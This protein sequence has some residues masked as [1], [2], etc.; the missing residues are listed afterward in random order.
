MTLWEE[1]RMNVK[2]LQWLLK[3]QATLLQIV[4]VAKGFRKG[5]PYAEQWVIVD[6]IARLVIPLLESESVNPKTLAYYDW[7]SQASAFSTGAE[8][9]QLGIDWKLITEVVLPILIAIL[10]ALAAKEDLK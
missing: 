7:D 4:E 6:K 9:A 8:Y 10:Q 3:N 1:M 5:S 2:V